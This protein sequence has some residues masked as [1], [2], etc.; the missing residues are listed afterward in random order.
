MNPHCVFR[1]LWYHHAVT[2]K[3]LEAVWI[4]RW[5]LVGCFYRVA[6]RLL[7]PL[8]KEP[9]Y[10]KRYIIHYCQIFCIKNPFDCEVT[11]GW[12]FT[13]LQ[14]TGNIFL[15]RSESW[16]LQDQG[17]PGPIISTWGN[18]YT[19]QHKTPLFSIVAW[20]IHPESGGVL[21]LS[22]ALP[23]KFYNLGSRTLWFFHNPSHTSSE[24]GGVMFILCFAQ[25]KFCQL[26]LQD[27]SGFFITHPTHRQSL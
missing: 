16:E 3:P 27:S 19:K 20:A 11:D 1:S 9:T 8:H 17:S 14:R 10:V 23:G 5:L 21:C 18:G 4:S 25:G 24:L 15:H 12:D 2:S 22:S 26:Q 7:C 6:L 13:F